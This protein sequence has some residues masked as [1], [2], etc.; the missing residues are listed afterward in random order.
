MLQPIL[1]K[2][3]VRER[4][5]LLILGSTLPLAALL[6][7]GSIIDYRETLGRA[8]MEV[9]EAA[10]LAASRESNVFLEARTLLGSLRV[11]PEVSALGGVACETA[12]TRVRAEN[13]QFN[14][15]G[16]FDA[17][18]M[19]TCHSSLR[20]QQLFGDPGLAVKV[21]A[22]GGP[23]FALSKFQIGKASGKPTVIAAMALPRVNGRTTGAIFASF[24]LDRL[25]DI[26]K[27]VSAG[28][29]HV[30]SLI[31]AEAGRL[32]A[33]HPPLPMAFGTALPDHPLV[34]FMQSSRLGGVTES[35]G[36]DGI[37]RIEGVAP[38]LASDISDLMIAVGMA[39]DDVLRPV[40]LR[41][42]LVGS[43]VALA[44]LVVFLATWWLG[45][46]TQLKPI[47][48]L[49]DTSLRIGS[50]DFAAR[51]SLEPWQ[52]PEFLRLAETLDDMAVKLARGKEAEREVARSQARYRILAE[53][54]ADLV[55]LI[56]SSG[57]RVYV[58]PAS[59]DM[60]GYE[61]DEMLDMPPQALAHTADLPILGKIKATLEAGTN[62]TNV[63]YRA[64]HREG[65]YVW[66]EVSGR[67]VEGDG[68]VV[69]L[70][71][72]ISKRKQAEERLE[73][74]N[75]RLVDL[76]STDSLTGLANRRAFDERLLDE[77]ARSVRD[78]EGLSVIMID[79][80]R[81]K[82]YNDTYG[83]PAGDE[84]LRKIAEVLKS[85][86]RRPGDMAARYGG[87]EFVA[88]LPKTD[89]ASA[90]RRA[91]AIMK[92]L[93]ALELPHAGS[94]FNTVSVSSGVATLRSAHGSRG[95]ADLLAAADDALYAAKAAGRNRVA[96]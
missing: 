45:Q 37:E 12:I 51:A 7:G 10:N 40:R 25:S 75:L 54:T 44:L 73:E 95:A 52:A 6:L 60:L 47:K 86:L 67:I 13:P 83:H 15:M 68:D 22:A 11:L 78:G 9:R 50:G 21:V 19:I 1:K 88:I 2:L 61:P 71:R 90:F 3:G 29:T 92:A 41:A 69:F 63:Q 87:E 18:G 14:T 20:R 65:H 8:R 80:D 55:T 24:N 31:E 17:N 38:L 56:D 82:A 72:D 58:S 26:A 16:V 84:C 70:M 74:T 34:R 43:F 79:V 28:G 33:R 32:I 4:L 94:E 85:E 91:E 53:N 93:S 39:R 62:V 5:L 64:R 23:D 46:L 89:L 66:V 42:I 48:H 27:D 76:A 96:A 57:K 30:V 49:T 35:P 59:R 77:V 81:F 36:L